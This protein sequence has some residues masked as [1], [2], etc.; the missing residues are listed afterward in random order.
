MS[1]R[2]L[3]AVPSVRAFIPLTGLCLWVACASEPTDFFAEPAPTA[4][5]GSSTAGSSGA[6]HG[7]TGSDQGGGA[8][9]SAGSGTAGG[10]SG[11]SGGSAPVGGSSNPG[12]GNT[13]VSGSGGDLAQGGSAQ[14]G[15]NPDGGTSGESGAGETGTGGT[16]SAGEGGMAGESGAG[17]GGTGGGS[18]GVGGGGAGMGGSAG[19][20]AGSGNTGGQPGTCEDDGDCSS[21]Q[22]CKKATCDAAT[23]VCTLRATACVGVDATLNPVCGCDHMTYYTACVAAHEGVNVATSG[24]CQSGAATCSRTAGSGDSCNPHRDRAACYRTR[25]TCNSSSSPDE[26]VCWVLPETCPD[27]DAAQLDCNNGE[28]E[29]V[30]LCDALERKRPIVRNSSSCD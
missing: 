29:C 1:G 27:E 6:G 9:T 17:T 18:G 20:T 7:G 15:T 30:G 12:G 21:A 16:T 24:E 10:G 5:K 3:K 4:G 25:T 19:S 11:A 26:G 22:Y 13:N 23:G 2:S 14:A 8:G 28:P